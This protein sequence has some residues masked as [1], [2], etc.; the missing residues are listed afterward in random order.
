L[1]D[2]KIAVVHRSDGSGTTANFTD[3][4]SKVSAPWRGS[5]GSDLLVRWPGG[6][7]AK[8]NDGISRTVRQTKN[9]I[10][11]VEYGHA[12]QTKLSYAALRNNAGQYAKPHPQSFQIAAAGAD[13][14]RTSDFDL[15]MTD[16][17]RD[18][19]YPIVATV[20]AL[21]QKSNAP[22]RTR[23]T[24][25]FFEWSLDKGA[26][27]ASDLGYIPLPPDLI[28]LIKQYWASNLRART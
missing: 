8:G 10:G 2:A 12:L 20:F 24:L 19:A 22:A 5:V 15:M 4:L 11:Y 7:G 28:T 25:N 21:M 13:C 16:V 1:P 9:S 6:T 26:K 3:Y 23:A 27:D 18:D 17:Q 14:T